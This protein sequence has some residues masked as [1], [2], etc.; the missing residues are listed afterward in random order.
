MKKIDAIVK[1]I[2]LDEIVTRLRL[3]G[4]AGMTVAEA[5]GMSPSTV[6]ESVFR[7]QRY[8]TPS[9]PRYQVTVVVPD[10]AVAHVVRAIIRAGQTEAPG[11]GIITVVDVVD[12]FRI[13]T[14]EHGDAAL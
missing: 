1:T 2:R 6:I 12:A 5:Q 11:D 8:A 13:R 3:I 9:A 7:G 14:G 10:D 4:V